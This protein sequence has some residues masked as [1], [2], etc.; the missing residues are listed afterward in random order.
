[1]A[2]TTKPSGHSMEPSVMPGMPHSWGEYLPLNLH[3]LES[4][5]EEG[6]YVSLYITGNYP[7]CRSADH[8]LA[9]TGQQLDSLEACKA[10]SPVG[11]ILGILLWA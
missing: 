4:R 6:K 9:L 8:R 1:M 11:I 7:L 3:S 10:E 2:D 5:Q